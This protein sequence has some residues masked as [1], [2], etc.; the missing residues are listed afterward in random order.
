MTSVKALDHEVQ[1][2][3]VEIGMR[4][5]QKFGADERIVT[6]MKSHHEDYPYETIES[7][8]VQDCRCYLWRPSWRPPRLRRELPQALAGARGP[9]KYLPCRR[10]LLPPS[11]QAVK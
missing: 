11:R 4:I 10:A 1:G 9:G 6:A 3:H 5:L 2:T 7:I 8:I